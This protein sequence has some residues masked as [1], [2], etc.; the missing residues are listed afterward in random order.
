MTQ[1][2]MPGNAAYREVCRELWLMAGLD[3]EVEAKEENHE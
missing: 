1:T 2:G 3:N